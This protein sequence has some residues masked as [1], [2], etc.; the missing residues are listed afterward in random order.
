MNKKLIQKLKEK[1]EKEKFSI[2]KE[3]ESFAKKGKKLKDDWQ[4]R[5]PHFNGGSGGQILEDAADEVEEY[6]TLLP[7]EFSLEKKLRD[8]N[9]ALKKIK[10]RK[11]G[12]CEKCQ[13]PISQARLKVLPAA[14]IC[15]KCQ[16]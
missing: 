2:E 8:I 16:K 14:R 3:L 1:L 5:F 4:A 12:I 11:Y 13:K 15:S 9:L 10:Q 6:S 7:I